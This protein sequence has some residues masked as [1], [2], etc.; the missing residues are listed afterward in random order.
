[1]P[2]FRQ[3]GAIGDGVALINDSS[4][5]DLDQNSTTPPSAGWILIDTRTGKQVADD[6]HWSETPLFQIGCCGDYSSWVQRFGGVVV[7]QNNDVLRVWLP[8]AATP[9]QE[10]SLS[11]P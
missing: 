9:A 4:I 6:Q 5:L 10:H 3:L 7:A 1:L 11:L 2:G 8:R